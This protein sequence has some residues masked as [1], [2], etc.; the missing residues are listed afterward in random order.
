MHHKDFYQSISIPVSLNLLPIFPLNLRSTIYNLFPL[1][2][3]KK[4]SL[5]YISNINI[6]PRIE[7]WSQSFEFIKA[8]LITGY[9][10]GT[11]QTLYKFSNGIHGNI[12]HSHNIFLE[13]AINHGL[14]SS[15]IIFFTIIF[16]AINSWKKSSN[17]LR[18]NSNNLDSEI[19]NFDK[20]WIISFLTF[21][22]IHMF[23][24][25]YFDG[26]ISTLA[27]LLL[28]GMRSIIKEKDNKELA[29]T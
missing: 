22:F 5:E 25:T 12:Q 26:R 21:L 18:N 20:A 29:N 2:L 3:I 27:W 28:A 7:I 15:L 13:I 11:F 10:A 24:I 1:E 16:I 14:P 9:G 4:T 23:D 8:N 19:K 6:F 17:N